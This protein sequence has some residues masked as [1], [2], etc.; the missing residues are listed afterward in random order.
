VIPQP[1]IRRYARLTARKLGLGRL[2]RA[3]RSS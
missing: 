2:R 1:E 3:M